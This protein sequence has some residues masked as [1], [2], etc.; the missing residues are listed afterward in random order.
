MAKFIENVEDLVAAYG[1]VSERSL[2]KVV[3]HFT[4]CYRKWIEASRF[5]VV[6]TI[7]PEGS[8]GSPR[9]DAGPVV[10]IA[11]DKTLLLPDWRGNNRLDTLINIVR[12]DRVSLMFMVPGS[13]SV[14]RV[15]GRAKLSTDA[16]FTERFEQKGIHPTSVIVFTLDEAYFQCAKALM[17]SGLWSRGD[18]SE[19]LPTAGD[20]LKEVEATFD[21]KTYDESYPEYAKSRMW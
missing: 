18:D 11:D 6:S 20:F 12:D 9:G 1:P 16:A 7:G 13:N 10:Q 8:D 2:T 17:R 19:G 21:G 14:V 15:N 4:P 5:C 3:R